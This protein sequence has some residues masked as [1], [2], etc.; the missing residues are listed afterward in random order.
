MV[1]EHRIINPMLVSRVPTVVKELAKTTKSR[2][3]NY[4]RE[5]RHRGDNTK[6][7]NSYQ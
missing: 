6:L 5:I 1:I 7:S 3:E 4:A 2:E